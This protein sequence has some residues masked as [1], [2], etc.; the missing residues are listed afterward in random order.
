VRLLASLAI[1]LALFVVLPAVPS[2]QASKPR[3]PDRAPVFTDVTAYLSIIEHFDDFT[4]GVLDTTHI[5]YYV[6]LITFGLFL[7]TKSVDTERWRG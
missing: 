1:A 3:P 6:S 4:K 5:I 7:T 2:G